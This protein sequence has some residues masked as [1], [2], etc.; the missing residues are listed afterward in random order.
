MANDVHY[1]TWLLVLWWCSW[2]DETL[3]PRVQCFSDNMPLATIRIVLVGTSHPG[4]I[5]AAA[6]AMKNM[7]L[8]QLSLVAPEIF[9]SAEATARASGADDVLQRA[10]IFSTLD[11]AVADCGLVLGCSARRRHLD[12]PQLDPREAAARAVTEASTVPVA[13]VFGRERTGL[14]NE[15]LD[16]CHYLV[17]IP[18]Q[19]DFSSLNLAAAVQVLS[20]ELRMA[21]LVPEALSPSSRNPPASHQQLEGLYQHFYQALVELEFIDPTNPRLL[22]R[23]LRRLFNRTRLETLEVNILRGILTAAQLRK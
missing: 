11:E 5:G 21:A 16:R 8:A 9:P 19:A 4:N 1:R 22:M 2:S 23:R 20:Y 15:E 14:T 10:Q 13:L 17:H 3:G 12:W 7:G 18:T 6:R